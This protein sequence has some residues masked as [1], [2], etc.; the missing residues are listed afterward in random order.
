MNSLSYALLSILARKSCSGYELQQMMDAF[1]QAKHSQIYPLLAK[2]ETK[3]LV[4]S[5]LI[6]QSGRPDKKIYTITALGKSVLQEWILNQPQAAPIHR[7]EFLIKVYAIWSVD[8]DTAKRL[9]EERMNLYSEKLAEREQVIKSME[10]EWGEEIKRMSSK[11]F[12]RYLIYRR[13]AW[14]DREE[15][16]WCKW[17]LDMLERSVGC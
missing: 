9:F 11:Q 8:K 17:A 16:A 7:D 5:Q 10:Q 3:K 12:G 4:I 1:W 14:L 15:L 6:E 2:L 13:R